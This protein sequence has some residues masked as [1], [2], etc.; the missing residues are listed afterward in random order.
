[1]TQTGLNENGG[2]SSTVDRGAIPPSAESLIA[3]TAPLHAK[4]LPAMELPFALDALAPVISR[5]AMYYHYDKHFF[6]YV[7][8][9]NQLIEKN[10]Y[11][12]LSLEDIIRQAALNRKAA[13]F[14]NA[15]QVWNHAFFWRCL[16]G[17][18][19]VEPDAI[20]RNAIS[21]TF[22]SVG[23]FQA[24]FIE[25]GVA[26]VGSGWLWLACHPDHGLVITT[27]DNTTPVWLTS[28]QVPLMVCDLW[29]H[30]YYLDWRNDRAGWLKAFMTTC[31]NW[32]FAGKQLA[33]V[34]DKRPQWLY[35]S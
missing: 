14:S 34:L 35:G 5:E 11:S 22:G 29:E 9:L 30:A 20:L 12:R 2:V 7:N 28:G 17:G 31:A 10:D 3:S 23:S 1:M 13:I 8:K 24:E 18:G 26:H 4:P 25:R 6:G 27:T 32:H 16:K 33:S 19:P 15:S 21:R